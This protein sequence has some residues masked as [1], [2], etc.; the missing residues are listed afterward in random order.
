VELKSPIGDLVELA[1]TKAATERPDALLISGLEM[2][3]QDLHSE[4]GTHLIK[5]LNQERERLD[6]AVPCVLLLWVSSPLLQGLALFAREL[7]KDR[8]RLRPGCV[9]SGCRQTQRSDV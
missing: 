2:T 3:F 9:R 7:E 4:H 5:Q 8:A 6:A 1:S